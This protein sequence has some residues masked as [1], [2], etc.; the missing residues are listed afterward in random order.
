MPGIRTKFENCFVAYVDLL[1]F[2]NKVLGN[3]RNQEA[4]SVLKDSLKICAS[5]PSGGKKASLGD[6]GYRKIDVQS[7]FFSD[8][9]VLFMKES[10]DNL[11]HLLFMIRYLQDKLWEKEL[12]MRGAI[13]HGEMYWPKT[14]EKGITLGKAL[15]EAHELESNVAIYPRIILSEGIYQYIIRNNIIAE[16]FAEY[17]NLHEYISTDEAGIHYLN[18]LHNEIKRRSGEEFVKYKNGFSIN[19][20][21][22]ESSN[23]SNIIGLVEQTIDNNIESS[24]YKVKIK[25][26]WLKKYL[27]KISQYGRHDTQSRPQ[28]FRSS[29]E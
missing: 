16:P 11:S 20:N 13:T 6:G 7:R 10:P 24:D 14:K 9:V 28:N 2:K 26:Q 19:W 25:Y 23:I 3:P 27:D 12:C 29:S 22:T 18:L 8:T 4:L 1:G 15:I 17:G 21:E 5:F